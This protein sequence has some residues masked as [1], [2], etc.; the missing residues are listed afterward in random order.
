VNRNAIRFLL[1]ILFLLLVSFLPIPDIAWGKTAGEVLAQLQG[2][3]ES[4]REAQLVEAAKKEGKIVL[5]G[6]TNIVVMQQLL[7]QFRK[8]YSFLQI[9]NY[10]ATTNRVYTKIQ[11][12]ARSGAHAVD[13]I[14]I[15]RD[16]AFKLKQDH[17]LELNIQWV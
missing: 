17:L 9:D 14:E 2:L 12:E 11:A 13:V 10:R 1:S 6:T 8:K 5:Y 3:Q 15:S 7:D 16:S 4:G